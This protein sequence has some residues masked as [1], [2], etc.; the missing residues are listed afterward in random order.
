MS[1]N[2]AYH[3]QYIDT[4]DVAHDQ[5]DGE[6]ENPFS[7]VIDCQTAD[8]LKELR[9]VETTGA[10]PQ[11]F[12]VTISDL[13]FYKGTVADP[14][15]EDITPDGI[16]TGTTKVILWRRNQVRVNEFGEVV[17]PSR[18]TYILGVEVDGTSWTMDVFAAVGQLP[19]EIT[20]PRQ[21]NEK[22]L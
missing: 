22:P 5:I 7:D 9:I 14:H 1:E 6:T 20:N 21:T 4:S 10:D 3:W 19:E 2:L 16:G 8:E 17:Q 13:K 15:N 18:T 12:C 11:V